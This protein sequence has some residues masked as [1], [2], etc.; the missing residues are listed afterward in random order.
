MLYPSQIPLS[1]EHTFLAAVDELTGVDA[2]RSNEKFL[3]QA[4]TVW[5][6]EVNTSKGST[7]TRVVDDFFDNTLLIKYD[8]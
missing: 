3:L 5:I 1:H 7:A 8:V 2:F 4:V 6:T